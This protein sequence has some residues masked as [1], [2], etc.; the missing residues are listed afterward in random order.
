[1]SI[2]V[3]LPP[4][5]PSP[6]SSFFTS[7]VLPG[8]PPSD[9]PLQNGLVLHLDAAVGVETFGSEANLVLLWPNLAQSEEQVSRTKMEA[10]YKVSV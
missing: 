1:M 5:P 4:S 7:I 10:I 6:P 9:L 2:R 8:G 3:I